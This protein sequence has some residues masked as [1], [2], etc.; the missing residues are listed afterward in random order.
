VVSG[1]ALCHADTLV[2]LI[3]LLNN[4][5]LEWRVALIICSANLDLF[6]ILRYTMLSLASPSFAILF[7]CYKIGRSPS[8]YLVYSFF[9]GFSG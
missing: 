9:S 5:P 7:S 6:D 1:S 3:E 8:I 4:V 2:Y